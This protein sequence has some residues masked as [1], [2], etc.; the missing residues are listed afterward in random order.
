MKFTKEELKQF[1]DTSHKVLEFANAIST[2]DS[3]N[4]R[5]N[6]SRHMTNKNSRIDI[7]NTIY[8]DIE[9]PEYFT[10]GCQDA[11]TD[12]CDSS[13]VTMDNSDIDDLIELSFEK[14][15]DGNFIENEKEKLREIISDL[16]F[17]TIEELK[18]EE[19]KA[20]EEIKQNELN[21]LARLQEKYPDF[22]GAN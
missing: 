18:E 15:L 16:I 9:K 22:K 6:N 20:K 12:I 11:I 8:K 17:L 5:I 7:L 19:D 14:M 13:L 21:E 3:I 4:R 2:I 10:N 1:V